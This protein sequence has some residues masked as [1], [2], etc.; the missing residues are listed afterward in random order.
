MEEKS[1][2]V[3]TASAISQ[4]KEEMAMR[5]VPEKVVNYHRELAQIDRGPRNRHERRKI[6]AILRGVK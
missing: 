3:K 4:M 2:S 5:E 6:T 1:L